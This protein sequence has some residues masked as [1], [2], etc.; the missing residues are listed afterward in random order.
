MKYFTGLNILDYAVKVFF[1][2]KYSIVVE[3]Y[4]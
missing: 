2:I 3:S 1:P 4:E